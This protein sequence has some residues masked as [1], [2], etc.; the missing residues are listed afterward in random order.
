MFGVFNWFIDCNEVPDLKT[1]FCVCAAGEYVLG[2]IYAAE[3]PGCDRVALNAEFEETAG[4]G[5]RFASVIFEFQ[6]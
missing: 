6:N 1:E 4:A 5:W 3:I 2:G